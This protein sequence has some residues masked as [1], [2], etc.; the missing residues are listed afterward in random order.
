MDE[1]GEAADGPPV[2]PLPERFDRR[3]RLG[4]FA[5]ARDALK[6]VTYAAVGAVLV[7]F[8][9]PYLWLVVVAGG[10]AVAAFRPDG[11]GLDERA[12]SFV[13]WKFRVWSGNRMMK[14]AAANP[15]SRRGLLAIGPGLYV[16]IIR[17]GGSPLAYLPPIDLARRFEL[18]RDLLRSVR[19][20]IAFSIASVPMRAGPVVPPPLRAL[21]QDR[22]ASAGYSELVELLC[23]RRSVRTVYLALATESPGPDGVSDLEVR[24]STLTERLGGLGL[25]PV[26]L[27]DRRLDD[28]ARRWGWSWGHPEI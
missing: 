20:G 17:T 12:V 23:R 26:R 21:R 9:S 22:P 13:L 11:R 16:A 2:V 25:R 28:A 3:L 15:V 7:P 24:V 8:T 18:F 1:M 27:R 5:S 14:S 6:F 4:P 19:G 10:F